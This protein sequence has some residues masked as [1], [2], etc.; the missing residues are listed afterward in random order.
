M[1]ATAAPLLV[2][3]YA[4]LAT[5]CASAPRAEPDGATFVIVRHAEKATDDTRDPTLTAVGQARAERLATMLADARL[6]AVYATGFRRT[7]ATAQPAARAHG[8]TVETYDARSAPADL[9]AQLRAR[10]TDGTVLIVGHSNTAPALAA[11]L[12]A[13][14]VEP[15]AETEYGIHYRLH[16]SAASE[17][18]ARLEVA[19]W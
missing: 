16:A 5:A 14:P 2:L 7:Q 12:C 11:A 9:A 3:A 1:H 6:K 13:C 19:S 8:L 18:P 10:H 4:T 15:M 17:A